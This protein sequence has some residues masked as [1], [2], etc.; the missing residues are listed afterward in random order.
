MSTQPRVSD[1][2][3]EELERLALEHVE[4]MFIELHATSEGVRERCQ[5]VRLIKRHPLIAAGLAATT[6][7]TIVILVR[8]LRRQSAGSFEA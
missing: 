1:L 8:Q 6:A 2:T 4:S 5:P 3:P 7:A